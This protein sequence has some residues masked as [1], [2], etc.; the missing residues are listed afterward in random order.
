MFINDALIRL[1]SGF[2]NEKPVICFKNKEA[3]HIIKLD[4]YYK[5]RQKTSIYGKETHERRYSRHCQTASLKTEPVPPN[6]DSFSSW[7]RG[8][9]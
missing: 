9:V 5:T 2:V 7:Y 4:L 3:C 6:C 8:A 1:T